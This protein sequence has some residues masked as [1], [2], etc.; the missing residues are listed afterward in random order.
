MYEEEFDV[1]PPAL[2]IPEEPDEDRGKPV[3]A[4]GGG[5]DDKEKAGGAKRKASEKQLKWCRGCRA[6]SEEVSGTK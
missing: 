4:A 5:G 6:I 2:V 3:A 1:C